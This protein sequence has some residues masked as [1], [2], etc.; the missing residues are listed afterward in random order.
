[1]TLELAAG[2]RVDDILQEKL[3]K[4][5]GIDVSFAP[6]DILAT[7]E[8]AVLYRNDWAVELSLE[9]SRG[10]HLDAEPGQMPKGYA[11]KAYPFVK[12]IAI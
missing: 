9:T 2:E 5:M 11:L 12:F 3:Y 10:M 4:L 1:M 8:L 6:G 7:D